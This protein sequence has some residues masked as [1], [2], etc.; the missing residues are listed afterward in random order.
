[1]R[2]KLSKSGRYEAQWN[3]QTDYGLVARIELEIPEGSLFA[4]NQKIHELM[5]NLEVH[6]SEI[7][8][9]IRKEAKTV[10]HNLGKLSVH[11]VTATAEKIEISL[12]APEDVHAEGYT[13][14]VDHKKG[15]LE[16][17]QR[18]NDAK[19]FDAQSVDADGFLHFANRLAE[20]ATELRHHRRQLLSA[21]LD[22]SDIKEHD[23]PSLLVDRLM[24][25]AA[26]AVHEIALRSPATELV[27]RRLTGDH[28]REEIFVSKKDLRDLIEK[29]PAECRG[30]F[31]CLELAGSVP[32]PKKAKAPKRESDFVDETTDVPIE[33]TD[34][35]GSPTDNSWDHASKAGS[36]KNRDETTKPGRSKRGSSV[37]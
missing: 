27:L 5:G 16:I 14:I 26:P 35:A 7:S 30:H 34:M 9:W 23:K 10:S 21:S 29:L 8:G 15:T 20:D 4:P 28:R 11:R 24:K 12:E 19:S 2:I 25:S 32:R 18:G 1:M 31:D 22:K 17:S 3:A 37:I 13:I 6:A 33:L 36:G